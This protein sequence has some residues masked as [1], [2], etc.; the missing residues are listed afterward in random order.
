[1]AGTLLAPVNG[2]YGF[3]FFTHGGTVEMTLDGA[4]FWT[5]RGDGEKI[6]RS[7]PLTLRKGPHR[8][9]LVYHVAHSPAAIDWIWTPPGGREAVVPSAVLRPPADAGPGPP[10]SEETLTA[11]RQH[12]YPPPAKFMP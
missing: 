2:D 5:T 9:E 7:P 12:R 1:M 11:M 8:V 10:L 4:P 6:E 3:G